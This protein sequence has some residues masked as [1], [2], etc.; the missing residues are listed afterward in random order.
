[1]CSSAKRIHFDASSRSIPYRIGSAGCLYRVEQIVA[2]TDLQNQ[3]SAGNL[4]AVSQNAI[5]LEAATFSE[6]T[7][8]RIGISTV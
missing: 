1:M 7:P 2:Q 8:R 3:V 6:S 4:N 5:A